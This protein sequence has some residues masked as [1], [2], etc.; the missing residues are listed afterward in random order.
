MCSYTA[1]HVIPNLFQLTF[2]VIKFIFDI[3]P[4]KKKKKSIERP[5]KTLSI[6]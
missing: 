1:L 2:Y 5:N 4:K 6:L 3:L